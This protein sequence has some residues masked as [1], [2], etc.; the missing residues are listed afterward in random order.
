M[1][2]TARARIMLTATMVI[3]GTIG[4]FRRYIPLASSV[5]A[6]VRGLVGAL[7]LLA[8]TALR[9]KKAD[10]EA[11]GRNFWKLLISGAFI[12]INWVLLFEAYRFT[13]VATATLCYYLA[14]IFV[15]LAAPFVLREKLTLRKL[16]C[17]L[18][19][20]GGMVLVSGVLDVGFRP[21]ELKG[22]AFGLGAAVLYAS[23]ILLN[24]TITNISAYD[25]TAVQLGAAAA[26]VL[27][28]TLMT[29]TL[30]PGFFTLPVLGMLL[31]V[32]IVHTG[33]AYALYFG[34]MDALPAHSIAIFSYI[35]PIVAILLSAMLLKEPMTAASW[36]G[37]VLILGAA[38][39]SEL[40]EKSSSP[41]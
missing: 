34:S 11:I 16:L 15:L 3:F 41:R 20:L 24:Q 10:R 31:L 27:P 6:F 4:I 29:E 8:V 39:I 33:V 22:V 26:A 7:F 37:A 13:T 36:V 2:N 30:S 25:K 21:Q 23:V 18:A 17:V 5:L 35:D 14:P 19:A 40:P 38:F 9:H 1:N 28:Y 32:G 12:G